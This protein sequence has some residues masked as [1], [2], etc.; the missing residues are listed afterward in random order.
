M[1]HA[2]TCR[3]LDARFLLLGLALAFPFAAGAVEPDPAG[4][5]QLSLEELSNIDITSVSKRSERL[6]D[7]AASV[8]V[9]S[10]EDIRRAGVR[11]LP[12]ALRL[13]PNLHVA[14]VTAS[15]HAISARG[16]NN[17]AANKLLVLIDGRSVYTP[18]F[19]GV[20]WD[21]QDV[22]LDDVDRIEVISG[23]GGTLWGVNAV[24]GI[25]NV[26]TRSAKE[27]QGGLIS[28]GGGN[29]DKDL[30]LR[31]GGSFGANGAYRVYA[32]S[33]ERSST[34][35]ADG[36]KAGDGW[37]KSQ[38]GFRTDWSR[39]GDTLTVHG[40]AYKG[41][42]GQ[43]QPGSVAV[44]LVSPPLGTMPVS[45]IN[46]TAN[47]S[48]TLQGGS[49][50]AVQAYLDRT[51]RAI[52]PA[53]SETLDLFDLQLQHS[54]PPAGIH[55]L[56]WGVEYRHGRDRITNSAFLAF[57]PPR[58]YFG[59]LPERLNQ[60]WSSVFVQDEM[61]LR[62]N[63]R[64]TVGARS[65]RNDYT[66]TELLPNLRLA[67]KFAPQHLLWTAASRTVR[68]PSR[69]D[70]DLFIPVVPPFLLAGGPNVRSEVADV[71]EIGYRG[72]PTKRITY[73]VTAFHSNYDHLRSTEL[74]P[75]RTS[76]FFANELEGKSTGIEMWG[77]YQ[78]G[79]N[80][81]LSAGFSALR[82]RLRV[83]PG[84][85]DMQSVA[86]QEGRDP[87]RM[88]MLR[89][90]MNLPYRTELDA[91]VRHVSAL[92]QPNVPGYTVVNLRLGWQARPDLEVSITGQNL[93]SARHAEFGEF[94]TRSYF[95]RSVFLKLTSRF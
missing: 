30:A 6:S 43:P 93:L 84:S 57:Q 54:L 68:A 59:F 78:A 39:A 52:P 81:R 46:L 5:V 40:N 3:C 95:E 23:P 16:F 9:I 60:T 11:S 1:V 83:K 31:Y 56:V 37:H 85:T 8:F 29:A 26:I 33:F 67:W 70:R 4:L 21:V 18:L 88:W 47:W 13:A 75:S 2:R 79:D 71:Y 7:A 64:F 90:S 66:G 89:S 44:N 94:A 92:A 36:R 15:G 14:Q 86:G 32:K 19:S 35:T 63:L 65:E 62:D 25:I 72:Q 48:H 34:K 74:A 38:V 51:K 28:A 45:G 41:S 55:S 27:T 87:D 91:T 24:N 10:G 49:D 80:W 82:E 76:I 58:P 50:L 53:F 77:T 61:R 73:S 69:L 17:N 20:F 22:M 42:E 12:D